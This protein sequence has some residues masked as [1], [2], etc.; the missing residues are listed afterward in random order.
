M[1]EPNKIKIECKTLREARREAKRIVKETGK[2][3]MKVLHEIAVKAGYN[4]WNE[5]I[6][7]ETEKWDSE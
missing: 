4:K 2:T 1:G 5:M 6:I 3:Y 7:K